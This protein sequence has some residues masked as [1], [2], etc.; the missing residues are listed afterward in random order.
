MDEKLHKNLFW[1]NPGGQQGRGRP[2]SRWTDR[3]GEDTRKL[4][5]RNWLAAAQHRSCW[6]HLHEEAKAHP[7]L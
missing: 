4:D 5:C 3:V 2:K 1:K 6:Q 7:G